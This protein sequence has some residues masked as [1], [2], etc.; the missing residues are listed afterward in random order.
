MH[1]SSTYQSP[2][3]EAGLR[4]GFIAYS[5]PGF[6]HAE[7]HRCVHPPAHPNWV[8]DIIFACVDASRARPTSDG[9]PTISC[10]PH[11]T[12]PSSRNAAPLPDL[13]RDAL[14]DPDWPRRA[15]RSVDLVD[16]VVELL[17]GRAS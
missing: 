2:G 15:C 16:D 4:V 14:V 7:D 8:S 17:V 12:P 13:G 5:L 11:G 10:F 9:R 3:A 1:A 6:A